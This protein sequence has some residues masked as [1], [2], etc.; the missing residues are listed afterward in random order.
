MDLWTLQVKDPAIRNPFF[1]S[2]KSSIS[3]KSVARKLGVVEIRFLK[4]KVSVSGYRS[5]VVR[6]TSKKSNDDS[7]A[8][9]KRLNLKANLM[10]CMSLKILF[11][12]D[13]L[14]IGEI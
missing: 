14:E 5:L 8:S 13:L 3:E 10:T 7:S 2:A 11:I 6:A 9:G 4:R 12:L 1:S